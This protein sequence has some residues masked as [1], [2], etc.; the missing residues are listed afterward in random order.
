MLLKMGL[1]REGQ[2]ARGALVRLLLEVDCTL[3]SLQV[4]LLGKRL[5]AVS[6]YK[7]LLPKVHCTVVAH[8]FRP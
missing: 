7:I 4:P 3:M 1:L 2:S 5:A 6:A 8:H